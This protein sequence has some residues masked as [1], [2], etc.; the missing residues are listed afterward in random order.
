MS[1]KTMRILSVLAGVLLV[2]A[3]I[4]CL[5]NQDVAVLSAGIL[6]G[7]FMLCAGVLEIIIFSVG[8]GLIFGSGWLLLDGVLTVLLSMLLLFNQWFTMVSLPI[9]FTLWLLFSGVSRFFSAFDLRVL[10]VRSWGLVLALGILL[11][12]LGIVGLLDPVVSTVAFA[13]TVGLVFILEGISIVACTLIAAKA[14]L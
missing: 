8:G 6:L 9:L 12:V 13:I 4:Y 11:L 2:A 10:G 7:L 3:G 14:D 5:C 1:K